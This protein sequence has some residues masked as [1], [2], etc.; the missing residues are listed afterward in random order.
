MK[1]I[2]KEA[3]DKIDQKLK[4]KI[5]VDLNKIFNLTKDEKISFLELRKK[6]LE[7]FN[8]NSLYYEKNKM[9][10]RID[11]KIS[12]LFDLEKDKYIHFDDVDNIIYNLMSKKIEY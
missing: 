11:T 7:Y 10:I 1:I 3:I 9:L 5:S 8:K 12:E 2:I 6:L 4:I